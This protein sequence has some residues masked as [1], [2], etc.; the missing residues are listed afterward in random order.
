MEIAD[1]LSSQIAS[2]LRVVPQI[3]R[4]GRQEVYESKA[5]IVPV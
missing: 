4:A 2:G 1:A 3:A 5:R